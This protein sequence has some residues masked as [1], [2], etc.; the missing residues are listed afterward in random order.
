MIFDKIIKHSLNHSDLV[1]VALTPVGRNAVVVEYTH[2][3]LKQFMMAK[4]ELSPEIIENL[5]ILCEP[6][7]KAIYAFY[8]DQYEAYKA[9]TF[10]HSSSITD[11]L[12]SD[13]IDMKAFKAAIIKF[14]D[15]YK[16]VCKLDK[17][18]DSLDE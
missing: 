6:V 13:Q 16:E 10:K 9:E 5:A 8:K 17:Y 12:K 18:R 11:M 4:P 2:A 3:L 7:L 14:E 15:S 1:N